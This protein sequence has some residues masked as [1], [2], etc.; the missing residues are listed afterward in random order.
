M[1]PSASALPVIQLLWRALLQFLTPR[2][3]LRGLWAW[4]KQKLVFWILISPVVFA[5]ATVWHVYQQA[6]VVGGWNDAPGVLI[7]PDVWARAAARW[8][9]VPA[10]V[11]GT[12]AFLRSAGLGSFRQL[13]GS[14]HTVPAGFGATVTCLRTTRMTPRTLETILLALGGGAMAGDML[15]RFFPTSMILSFAVLLLLRGLGLAGSKR[16]GPLRIDLAWGG[17]LVSVAGGLGFLLSWLYFGFY[18]MLALGGGVFLWYRRTHPGVPTP[19]TTVLLCVL[20]LGLT[21][22]A[23]ADDGSFDEFS[24]RGGGPKT[25]SGYLA[26][27][28]GQ[29]LVGLG[30]IGGGLATLG[31]VF[32]SL[33]GTMLGNAF[34]EQMN[35][36]QGAMPPPLPPATNTP[37]MH[38][39]PLVTLPDDNTWP[40]RAGTERDG[41]VWF[42]PP[43]DEGGPV[44]MS[45]SEFED[46]RSH[47]AQGLKWSNRHG[48]VTPEDERE[49]EAIIARSREL[50]RQQSPDVKAAYDKWLESR[51]KLEEM[52]RQHAIQ[53]KRWEVEALERTSQRGVTDEEFKNLFWENVEKD[54]TEATNTL[55]DSNTYIQA[56]AGILHAGEAVVNAGTGLVSH[57][58]NH[59]IDS[60]E[61]AVDLTIGS[62]ARGAG[63]LYENPNDALEQ[64]AVATGSAVVHTVKA[65]VVDPVMDMF[66]PNKTLLQRS[67]AVIMNTVGNVVMGKVIQGGM[68]IAGRVAGSV[69]EKG[70]KLVGKITKLVR[71][72]GG[73]LVEQGAKTIDDIAEAAVRKPPVPVFDNAA[74]MDQQIETMNKINK[75]FDELPNKPGS[76][77][78][79]LPT[80]PVERARLTKQLI[81][82][83][84]QDPAAFNS[85]RKAMGVAGIENSSNKAVK[86]LTKEFN[87]RLIR[88]TDQALADQG[89]E[90]KRVLV[91]GDT[92]GADLDPLFD[93]HRKMPDGTLQRVPDAEVQK[94]VSETQ[95]GIFK[96]DDYFK[97]MEVTP[98]EIHRNVMN[99]HPEKFDHIDDPFKDLKVRTEEWTRSPD[100]GL[101]PGPA[102]D[103]GPLHRIPKG[104]L[105]SEN[106]VHPESLR[107]YG[108]VM[109]VKMEEKIFSKIEQGVAPTMADQVETARELHKT[110]TRTLVPAAEKL[111][112]PLTPEMKGV[113]RALAA[114]S[115]PQNFNKAAVDFNKVRD[116]I[117]NQLSR[118]GAAP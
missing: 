71:G 6:F 76:R 16:E 37:P 67:G 26:T 4:A 43:W 65:V 87:E 31:A 5:V 81:Q 48:W 97:H 117:Q 33:F 61:K 38:V 57:V 35:L 46:M 42:Q 58:V 9:G 113:H 21:M 98:D 15:L 118:L 36:L 23:F 47:Q 66:D 110:L 50:N 107:G 99:A 10:I 64:A 109:D 40:P 70:G 53:Q 30:M 92:A 49:R 18:G 51:D 105:L 55:S 77:Q 3:L 25:I 69:M 32:G 73:E 111:G 115:D 54:V 68:G 2:S 94:I 114:L 63:Y 34:K 104:E 106:A 72:T 17:W 39:D 20:S 116:V 80:D 19:P 52:Q 90:V 88:T 22:A 60:L 56:G 102:N 7:Q 85:A 29:K 79:S 96:N 1:N 24:P 75:V 95:Q 41:K 11:T 59:P 84:A 83:Q 93:L 28:D 62:V 91:A 101:N 89:F 44:W 86:E 13:F 8:T 103:P 45:K 108:K 12:V 100:G 74:L 82:L 27:K 14:L 112:V 78:L